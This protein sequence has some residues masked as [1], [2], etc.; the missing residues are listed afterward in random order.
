MARQSKIDG[1]QYILIDERISAPKYQTAGS[2]GVDLHACTFDGM[3][4][5]GRCTIPPGNDFMVG[6]GLKL[7]IGS[8]DPGLVGFVSPR[9][10]LGKRGLQLRNTV[11]VIDADYQGEVVL[12]CRNASRQILFIDPLERIAQIVFLPVFQ[13][14]FVAVKEFE[15]TARGDGGIGSTG[16]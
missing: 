2:A 14:D 7:H 4:I 13:T 12:L 16:K 6:T 9:S 10:S 11:G 1:M 5:K 8:M 3:K 15:A